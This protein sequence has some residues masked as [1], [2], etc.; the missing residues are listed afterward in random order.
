[1]ANAE[2]LYA[3]SAVP[4]AVT[5]REG[6]VFRRRRVADAALMPERLAQ[7]IR[8][9]TDRLLSRIARSALPGSRSMQWRAFKGLD[10]ITNCGNK[11]DVPRVLQ[12]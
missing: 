5:K 2:I 6:S 7:L 4:Q 11:S 3:I 12:L 10:P 9:P 1:M 8:R